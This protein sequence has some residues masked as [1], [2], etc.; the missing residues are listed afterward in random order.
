METT[1]KMA[2]LSIELHIMLLLKR[3]LFHIFYI[4]KSSDL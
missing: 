1:R 2:R 4:L 3:I